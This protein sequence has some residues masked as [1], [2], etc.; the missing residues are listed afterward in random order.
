M[1]RGPYAK[2]GTRNHTLLVAIF[3]IKA[4]H[5]FWGY[6]RVWAYVRLCE[7]AGGDS[8][9]DL[10]LDEAA[11]SAGTAQSAAQ[12]QPRVPSPETEAHC[13]QSLLGIVMTKVLIDGLGWVYVGL[14]LD[15]DLKKI[16]CHYAGHQAKTWHW[17]GGVKYGG[18]T[19]VSRWR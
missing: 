9:A 14:V 6:R 10:S 2:I 17:L 19:A 12:S 15:W 16:V 11:W 1:K 13:A 7:A 5:S 18:A 3:R 8:K 4:D